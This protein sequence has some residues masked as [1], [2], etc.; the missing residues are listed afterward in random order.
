MNCTEFGALPRA[1]CNTQAYFHY[2]VRIPLF[3]NKVEVDATL[4]Q[5]LDNGSLKEGHVA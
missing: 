2:S 3:E 5:K 4:H 1:S